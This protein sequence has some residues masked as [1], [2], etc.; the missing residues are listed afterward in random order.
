MKIKNIKFKAKQL[1]SGKWFEGDLVRLGNRVCIGGDHIKD[2]I[3][4]VDPSTVCQF[5]GLKDCKGNEIWEHDLIHFV[6]YKP[7]GEVIWSEEDY[8][9]M[10]ASENEPLYLLPHVLEIGKIERVGNKFDKK[11]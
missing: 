3:T 4:D 8:A 6:G 11:K 2:G 5:T 9:F 7:I 10:A 1:N